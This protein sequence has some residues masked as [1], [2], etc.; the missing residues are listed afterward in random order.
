MVRPRLFVMGHQAA[1]HSDH[2]PE[3]KWLGA[4][5]KLAHAVM[6]ALTLLGIDAGADYRSHRVLCVCA[7]WY[8][9]GCPTQPSDLPPGPAPALLDVTCEM[10][11]GVA[12]DAYLVLRSWET[13][14]E[15]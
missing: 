6:W 10:P 15:E 11:R 2:W 13:H 8:L 14:G 9:G 12:G 1:L 5:H 3:S 4:A 7:G